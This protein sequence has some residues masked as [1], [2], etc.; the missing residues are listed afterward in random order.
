M[1]PAKSP[2][3][4]LLALSLG[5]NVALLAF[6]VWGHASAEADAIAQL[7]RD[8][9]AP[10]APAPLAPAGPGAQAWEKLKTGSPAEL[11][12][13]LR[14]SG[15]PPK[16]QRAIL[17]AH[18][19][20]ANAARLKALDLAGAHRPFWQNAIPDAATQAAS[21]QIYREMTKTV[22][23]LLGEDDDETR[24]IF[25]G[26]R[27]D[28]LAPAKAA[29]V[30]ALLREFDDRRSDVY[31]AGGMIGAEQQKQIAALEQEQR[32]ALAKILTPEELM[33][34]ELRNSQTSQTLRYS[35]AAFAPTEQEFRAIYALQADFDQRF[36]RIYSL[37][38]PDEQ[39]A[40][41]DAQ[42][43]LT[44]QIKSVLGPVRA[45]DYTR[46][47]NYDYRQLT[48]LAARLDFPAGTTDN[49]WKIQRSFEERRTEIYR[50]TTDAAARTASLTA[51]QLEA[52]AAVTPVV[53]ARYVET[54]AQ[55][56]GRWMQSLVPT[57]PRP[58]PVPA[59]AVPVPRN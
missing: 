35:L 5:L 13:R 45:E 36:G 12:T 9:P 41:S 37:P 15:F 32:A 8:T 59:P 39:R 33:D 18:L 29:D 25:Q 34:Y 27:L 1:S 23:D 55:Y 50:T 47:Q 56:G 3:F 22:R 24:S 46:A 48:Q 21:R 58:A 43:Q 38:S 44:E 51:L 4:A 40:R 28:G 17:A 6:L 11:A 53:G 20:E 7:R 52:R 26:R 57:V 30:R 49:L 54:Y 14:E 2:V 16:V 10:T 19:R 31:G 42:R